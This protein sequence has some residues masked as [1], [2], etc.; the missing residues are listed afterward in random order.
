[1]MCV[2][3]PGNNWDSKCQTA[4]HVLL[5]HGWGPGGI[6]GDH[7]INYPGQPHLWGII[8]PPSGFASR[9]GMTIL[10]AARLCF[11]CVC[12]RYMYGLCPCMRMS[13]W[14]YV[15]GHTHIALYFILKV[16]NHMICVL[17]KSKHRITNQLFK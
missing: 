11:L 10:M 15:H 12:I 16:H 1:M 3:I 4:V 17:N 14:L 2:Y 13:A 7:I 5:M 8:P 9:V 6:L